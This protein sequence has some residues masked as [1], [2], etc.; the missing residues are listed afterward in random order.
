[1]MLAAGYGSA[2]TQNGRRGS[3][4]QLLEVASA[5]SVASHWRVS[6]PLR[7]QERSGEGDPLTPLQRTMGGILRALGRGHFRPHH[8]PVPLRGG[9]QL[10]DRL[11]WMKQRLGK[12]GSTLEQRL[13]L[14][15]NTRLQPLTARP[16]RG[17]F[18]GRATRHGESVRQLGGHCNAAARFGTLPILRSS[19]P[20]QVQSA[21]GQAQS[22]PGQIRSSRGQIL[23]R[24]RTGVS[25][26]LPGG[27]VRPCASSQL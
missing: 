13:L 26:G 27:L 24:V 4:L 15:G 10:P 19:A 23:G 9:P 8:L 5:A 18:R 25:Y 17:S 3:R 16:C 6:A 2:G 14:A 7:S 20:G 12:R 22:G 21:P 11:A 1:M